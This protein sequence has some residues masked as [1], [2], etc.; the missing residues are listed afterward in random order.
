MGLQRLGAL[1]ALH[2]A[3]AYLLALHPA[4][5]A[6]AQESSTMGF[7]DQRPLKSH[8]TY[9]CNDA[10][11]VEVPVSGCE[12]FLQAIPIKSVPVHT[13][14][15]SHVCSIESKQLVIAT[16]Q[17]GFECNNAWQSIAKQMPC[18]LNYLK[19]CCHPVTKIKSFQV[20]DFFLLKQKPLQPWCSS[21]KSKQLSKIPAVHFSSLT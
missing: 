19:H 11:Q 8:F 12:V 21:S 16:W 10:V 14:H 5:E 9:V 7:K 2:S 15:K 1:L 6:Q 17:P 4:E 18:F 3:W 13:S 20:F